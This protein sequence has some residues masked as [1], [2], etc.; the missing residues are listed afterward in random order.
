MPKKKKLNELK[1][2]IMIKDIDTKRF[3]YF[4]KVI[5]DIKSGF[6]KLNGHKVINPDGS[7]YFID[8][9]FDSDELIRKITYLSLSNGNIIDFGLYMKTLINKLQAPAMKNETNEEWELLITDNQYKNFS[10]LCSKILFFIV[11]EIE[12]IND[13]KIALA[14]ADA[15]GMDIFK[16]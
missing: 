5:D 7:K 16:L 6:I 12:K 4:K 10:T 1:Y 3:L 8:E 14:V 2:D 11:D 13:N 15:V 9:M